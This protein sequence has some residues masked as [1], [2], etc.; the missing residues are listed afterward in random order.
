MDKVSTF[1]FTSFHFS[2]IMTFTICSY[3]VLKKKRSKLL[4]IDLRNRF[5]GKNE[6]KS[7]KESFALFLQGYFFCNSRLG[8]KMKSIIFVLYFKTCLFLA[9]VNPIYFQS[10]YVL[11]SKHNLRLPSWIDISLSHLAIKVSPQLAARKNPPR[12]NESY[13]G[14]LRMRLL[15]NSIWK[16][17]LRWK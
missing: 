15:E 8:F 11:S 12:A 13:I 4:R 14:V 1:L 2:L 5:S 16:R 17:R 6:K 7:L 10:V 3:F 9:K